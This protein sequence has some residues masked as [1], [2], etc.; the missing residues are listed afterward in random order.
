MSIPKEIKIGGMQYA[1]TEKDTVDNNAQCYGVCVYHD[2]HI[3]IKKE[4]SAERKEQTLIHEMMHGVFFESGF[5]DHEEEVVNRVSAV[6]YQVLKDND[7]SW[8]HPAVEVDEF[9]QGNKP[10]KIKQ[11]L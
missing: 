10:I 9:Y 11:M 4:L 7:F 8:I 6:L 2:T 3:E 1:V 5:E